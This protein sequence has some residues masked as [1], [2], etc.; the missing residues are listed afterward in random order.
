MDIPIDLS[1]VLW[2][3]TANDENKVPPYIV[4]RCRVIDV[5]AYKTQERKMI[6]QNYF[7]GQVREQ[8][9]L[10]F[11]IEVADSVA[12]QIARQTESLR[13]AKQLLVDLIARELAGKTPGTVR[14][15]TVRTW[16]PSVAR[17]VKDDYPR[18]IGFALGETGSD[19]PA[20]RGSLGTYR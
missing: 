5:P 11:A 16:D 2:I 17:S 14:R 15:L 12:G 10:D 6:I 4:N 13:E 3:A 8:L 9:N 19:E 18:R 7:P 1:K 20:G